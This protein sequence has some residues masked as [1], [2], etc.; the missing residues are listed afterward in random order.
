MELYLIGL[1]NVIEGVDRAKNI[2]KSKW[3][4]EQTT[5]TCAQGSLRA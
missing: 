4:Y 1:E 3:L 5:I 2:V